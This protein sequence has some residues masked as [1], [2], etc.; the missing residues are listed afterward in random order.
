MKAFQLAGQFTRYRSM[1]DRSLQIVFETQEAT[2]EM[3][4]N[5]QNSF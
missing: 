4:S 2:P 1:V 5:I 3:L